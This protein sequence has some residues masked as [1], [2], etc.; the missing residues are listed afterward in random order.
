M[1]DPL[2]WTYLVGALVTCLM[3]S[4]IGDVAV[5]SEIGISTARI[6]L[7][8]ILQVL[9]GPSHDWIR[10]S[11]TTSCRGEL[12][13]LLKQA[14]SLMFQVRASIPKTLCHCCSLGKLSSKMAAI[15]LKSC[16]LHAMQRL[17]Y[18]I[19]G[20]LVATDPCSRTQLAHCTLSRRLCA[21]KS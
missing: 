21:S 2:P 20:L 19:K 11:L 10:Q 15:C 14:L 8:S 13:D 1:L 9:L 16:D 4:R 18:S 5:C 3:R 17:A 7:L 6:L 12:A